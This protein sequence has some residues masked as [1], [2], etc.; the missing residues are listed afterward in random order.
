MGRLD[1]EQL[2]TQ[3]LS[4]VLIGCIFE[5]MIQN[6]LFIRNVIIKQLL[7]FLPEYSIRQPTEVLPFLVKPEK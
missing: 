7:P 5:G 2:K 3:R 4:C 1:A 6:L